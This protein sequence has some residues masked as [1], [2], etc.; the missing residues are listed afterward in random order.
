MDDALDAIGDI[1]LVPPYTNLV[2]DLLLNSYKHANS[3]DP[4]LHDNRLLDLKSSWLK[5]PFWFDA[6]QCERGRQLL[7]EHADLTLHACVFNALVLCLASPQTVKLLEYSSIQ[8]QD[9]IML[10]DTATLLLLDLILNICSFKIHHVN[11]TAGHLSRGCHGWE[12]LVRVRAYFS[13]LR[14]R[15]MSLFGEGDA[16]PFDHAGA[17]LSQGYCTFLLSVVTA[18][19]LEK[20][21]SYSEEDKMAIVMLW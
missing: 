11:D 8:S 13:I 5:I 20:F 6:G 16:W 9:M 1:C 4:R 18:A 19:I 7:S 21:S 2:V 17:P 15:A 10:V 12:R 14:R 3:A